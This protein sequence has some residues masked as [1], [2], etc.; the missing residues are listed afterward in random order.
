MDVGLAQDK[1]AT[2]S[3]GN[4]GRTIRHHVFTAIDP[5]TAFNSDCTGE[6]GVDW[7]TYNGQVVSGGPNY[8]YQSDWVNS[9]G[10]SGS[11]GGTITLGACPA[12]RQSVEPAPGTPNWVPE[13]RAAAA[14]VELDGYAFATAPNPFEDGTVL[15][16]TIP[17]ATDVH[18]T[19]YDSLGRQV[20]VLVDDTREAGT[21][22]LS[23]AG[24]GLS[25][26]TYL[27]HIVAG[28]F[29]EARQMTL[30]R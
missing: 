1:F 12:P 16:Y 17:E 2:A 22:T 25:S 24:T 8:Q 15:S 28:T 30:T 27:A 26:G 6:F 11:I 14:Q 4:N 5:N 20:A 29:N 23:F 13:D 21:H 18:I 7:F 9:C 10:L 19:V 3:R